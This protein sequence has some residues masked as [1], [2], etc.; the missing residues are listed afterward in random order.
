MISLTITADTAKANQFLVEFT[1]SLQDR[2]DL[3]A[4]LG[5]RLEDELQA[6]FRLK[7][8]VPNKMGAVKTNFWGA[9]AAATKLEEV[10]DSGAT[11]TVADK[12]F[13]IHL[14]GGKIVPTAGRKWL[15]IPLIKEA[16]G[17]RV[18]DYESKVGKKLFRL[19]GTGVLVERSREGDRSTLGTNTATIR[20]KSGAF[21]PVQVRARS[22]VRPVY[23]LKRSVTL[24]KDPHALP[25]TADLLAALLDEGNAFLNRTRD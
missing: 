5:S 25:P 6:H 22:Q 4:A 10:S 21:R 14:F 18:E 3:N 2:R 13:R 12:R 9:V 7:N 8:A 23:A 20:G 15:T 16:R 19:P 11:V 1:G 24:P 17:L